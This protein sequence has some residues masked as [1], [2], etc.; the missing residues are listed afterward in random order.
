MFLH[1]LKDIKVTYL[2]IFL[3]LFGFEDCQNRRNHK[4]LDTVFLIFS[5][6]IISVRPRFLTEYGPRFQFIPFY[7]FIYLFIH[8]F[9]RL[10]GICS[11]NIPSHTRLRN[12]T[13][14]PSSPAVPTGPG[15]P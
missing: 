13:I 12:L 5:Q 6:V 8:S 9:W 1:N 3:E 15:A 11:I 7:I 2:A 4:F 14:P 10:Y